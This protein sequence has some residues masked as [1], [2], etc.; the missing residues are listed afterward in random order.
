MTIVFFKPGRPCYVFN[1]GVRANAVG[2][3]ACE[4]SDDHWNAYSGEVA[5]GER[6]QCCADHDD[7]SKPAAARDVKRGRMRLI[8]V[9]TIVYVRQGPPLGHDPRREMSSI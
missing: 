5:G 8:L 4:K 9:P 1:S 7:Q 3:K 2:H 6:Q